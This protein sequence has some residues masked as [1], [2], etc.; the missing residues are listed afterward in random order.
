MSD[1]EIMKGTVAHLRRTRKFARN[2]EDLVF[3][4]GLKR[5]SFRRGYSRDARHAKSMR[6]LPKELHE[7]LL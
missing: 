3:I 1:R 6:P 7:P 2:D 4:D 5:F